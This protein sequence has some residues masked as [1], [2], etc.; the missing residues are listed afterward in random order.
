MKLLPLLD[1]SGNVKF[2]A[3]PR[4]GWMTDLDGNGVSLIAVDA[5]YDTNGVQLGGGTAITSGLEMAKWCYLSPIA[6]LRV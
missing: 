6:K 1:R 5:V 2:W 3:D 4:S